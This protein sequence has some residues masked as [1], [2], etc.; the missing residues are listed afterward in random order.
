MSTEHRGWIGV[1]LDGTLARYEG[2]KRVTDIGEPVPAML[3]RVKSWRAE[4]REVRVF[5]A[6]VW[7]ITQL[8]G[9]DYK[10]RADK[11]IQRGEEV[12]ERRQRLVTA[13]LAAKA[14]RQWCLNHV[15]EV[16]P[17]T[18]VK[19]RSMIELWDDRAVCVE[20]NTGMVL[21]EPR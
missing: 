10:F 21:G 12:D 5:T 19:D 4:G 6:R 1:D 2:W 3:E 14:I 18:C 16:L 11:W 15:G 17:I 13:T 20:R 8:M 9:K 7:P